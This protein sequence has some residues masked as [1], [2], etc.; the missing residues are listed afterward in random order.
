[1][2]ERAGDS[3]R[4]VLTAR[5]RSSVSP[6][7]WPA[8]RELRAVLDVNAIISEA[9]QLLRRLLGE[10]IRLTT[11]APDLWPAGWRI[12][13]RS[14]RCCS[15]RRQRDAM[16]NGGDLTITT[17]NLKDADSTATPHKTASA[18]RRERERH[19][20]HGRRH[21]DA[22]VQAVLQ[23]KPRAGHRPA[24]PCRASSRAAGRTEEHRRPGT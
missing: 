4:T 13:R 15:I 11:T 10:H 17:A 7:V 23:T 24:R 12:A 6:V 18:C 14:S 1:M 5:P 8:A 16:P 2:F 3:S 21:A 9:E 20:T 22:G 19:G